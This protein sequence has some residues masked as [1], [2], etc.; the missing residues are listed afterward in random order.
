MADISAYPSLS[1][2]Y[3]SLYNSFDIFYRIQQIP[4]FCVYSILVF[5]LTMLSILSAVSV[6]LCSCVCLAPANQGYRN[7]PV[8]NRHRKTEA[9]SK[10]TYY[11]C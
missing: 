2:P 9:C 8:G 5:F 10:I 6:S 1:Y 11:V 7:I 4:D 3:I